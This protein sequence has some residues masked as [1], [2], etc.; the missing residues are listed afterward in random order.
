MK[1]QFVS[2]FSIRAVNAATSQWWIYC[3]VQPIVFLL[4]YFLLLSKHFWGACKKLR[5]QVDNTACTKSFL[6]SNINYSLY[7]TPA[8]SF[9]NCI[10]RYST[11]ACVNAANS[12]KYIAK[13]NGVFQ[14]RWCLDMCLRHNFYSLSLHCFGCCVCG[15]PRH[16]HTVRNSSCCLKEMHSEKQRDTEWF[17]EDQA[18]SL[19]YPLPTT[20]PV[21]KLDRRHTRRLRKRDNLL[22]GE[23]G[24]VGIG[25]EPNHTT[26][27]KPDP[28]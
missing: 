18:F 27:R 14:V 21:S 22:R 23:G 10:D 25:V 16:A 26:A 4:I 28:L 13:P 8:T 9:I 19:S 17:I 6:H 5:M 2:L 3:L 11:I 7:S 20:S 12:T 1:T 15:G 24:G